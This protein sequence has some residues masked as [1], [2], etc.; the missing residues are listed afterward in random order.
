[1]ENRIREGFGALLQG[2]DLA[3]LENDQHSVFGLSAEFELIYF[4]PAYGRFS[5]RNGGVGPAFPLGTNLLDVIK[6]PMRA[7]YQ[8]TFTRVLATGI[9]WHHEYACHSAELFRQ[10]YQGVYPLMNGQGLVV[11][12]SARV[13]RAMDLPG[14]P[15]LEV[16]YVQS[17]GLLT[18]CSN[19]RRTLRNDDTGVWDWVPAW[20]EAMPENTSHSLC[21]TCADYYWKHRGARPH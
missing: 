12:N 14:Q 21:S 20:V 19:C 5:D 4:N 13:E 3:T 1:V 11:I 18:Q 17:T 8:E 9:A 10:Y 2:F 15:P 16:T 7:L 6:G